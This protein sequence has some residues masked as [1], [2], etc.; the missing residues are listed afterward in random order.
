MKKGMLNFGARDIFPLLLI[1]SILASIAMDLLAG[2]GLVAAIGAIAVILIAVATFIWKRW[3]ARIPPILHY[4]FILFVSIGTYW[5]NRFDLYKVFFFHDIL[6]HFFSGIIIVLLAAGS[7]PK[8]LEKEMTLKEKMFFLMAIAIAAASLW[9]I[10]EF[11]TDFLLWTDVQRNLSREWEIFYSEHQNP[12]I[13]DTM[14]DIIN[15]TL[16]GIV[17]NVVVFLDC[18]KKE[19]AS[20]QEVSS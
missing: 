11:L 12:G 7:M 15:G 16:G 5:S 9:E 17:G 19:K 10:M 3:G 13:V 1:A 4:I 2:A 14:N 6:L 18:R 20:T 8:H